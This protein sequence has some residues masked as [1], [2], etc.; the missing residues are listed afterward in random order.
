MA[1]QSG[2]RESKEAAELLVYVQTKLNLDVDERALKAAE[3][4][5]GNVNLLDEFT[6]LLCGLIRAMTKQQL[7]AIV[8]NARSAASRRLADW[9]E[10]HEAADKR[11]AKDE[12]RA[13]KVEALRL[14][15][16][17]KMTKEEKWAFEVRLPG[18][19]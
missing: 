11:K 10:E 18:E 15:A 7:A 2:E 6:R 1:Y 12:A 9:W 16:F 14:A 5:Y 8:Y 17:A 19:G 13:K 4:Y 3:E